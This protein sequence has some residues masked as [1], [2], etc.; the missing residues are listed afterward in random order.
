[1]LN[2]I[3]A[4]SELSRIENT[5]SE[6]QQYNKIKIFEEVSFSSFGETIDYEQQNY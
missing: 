1:M 2:L 4:S 6:L 5:A 3:F